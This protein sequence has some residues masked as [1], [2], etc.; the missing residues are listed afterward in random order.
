MRIRFPWPFLLTLTLAAIFPMQSVSA[1]L[2]P[3]TRQAFDRYVLL[4]DQ[5]LQATKPG[6][7]FL[8]V[9]S[10]PALQQSQLIQRL[11]GGEVISEKLLEKENGR[12]VPVPDGM[13]HHWI[14]TVFV[15]GANLQQTLTL[16]QDYDHHKDIYTSEVVGSKLLSR[17]GNRFRAY[18]R[19]YK[20]KIIGVTL[21]TEHAAEYGTLNPKQAFSRSHTTKIAEVDDAGEKDEREKPVG[22][23]NGFLWALNSFWRIEEA[24]G[25][26]Y[27]QC[28]AVTLTRDI[29]AILSF[30]VK[31]F[32]TEVPRESLYNTLTSTRRA[33]LQRAKK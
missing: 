26:V 21:N 11:R 25:G 10:R 1:E 31:P 17:D 7:S 28:E 14:A 22:K 4:V 29:P 18:L 30:A 16:L 8:W 9:K 24:D 3:Q 33:L 2:K 13:L 15:P 6:D 27:V 23:D 12:E 19:F 5:R 20:K 32:V